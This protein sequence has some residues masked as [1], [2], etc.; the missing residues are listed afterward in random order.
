MDTIVNTYRKAW[1][2][3]DTS[4]S[5]TAKVATV[6]RPSGDGVV[7]I[8]QVGRYTRNNVILV[9]YGIGSD[10]NTM[11]MRVIN[12]KEI[13]GLWIPLI[14][15][16]V[17]CTL[18]TS[19]GVAANAVLNTERFADTIALTYGNAGIDCQVFSPANNTPGHVTVDA[20][21][22]TILEVIFSRGG[23]ATSCNALVSYL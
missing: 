13:S 18:S 17:A 2:T 4:N 16:E 8:E 19:V 21:G 15:C 20:K 10:N 1:A 9:P 14:V 3:N 22:A 23:S 12:W 7:T 5:F 6:T 11:S